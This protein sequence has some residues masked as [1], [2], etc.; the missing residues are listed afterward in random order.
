MLL[1]HSLAVALPLLTLSAAQ[2]T[3]PPN[4][5][6]TWATKAK[7]T[8]TGPVRPQTPLP[9]PTNTDPILTPPRTHTGLLR[10]PLGHANRAHPP[11]HSLL[12]HSRR[13]LRGSVLPRD[14]EPDRPQLPERHHA[15]AA[16]Q[17]VHECDRRPVPL[18]HRGR[19]EA[20]AQHAVHV[21]E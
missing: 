3:L 21:W 16:R 2:D 17:M 18:A 8:L 13:P 12:L 4:L 9:V 20:V 7:S 15:V 19:W 10:P 11:R 14:R 5:V 1:Y 6:G